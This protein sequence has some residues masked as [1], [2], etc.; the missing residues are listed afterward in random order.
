MEASY[1]AHKRTIHDVLQDENNE[2]P[3]A[4]KIDK[5]ELDCC[6]SLASSRNVVLPVSKD[7]R[8]QK[9]PCMRR[10]EKEISSNI[11]PAMRLPQRPRDNLCLFFAAL[12]VLDVEKQVAFTKGDTT[13]PE[14]AFLEWT[15][16]DEHIQNRDPL[17]KGYNFKDLHAYLQHL[18]K[19]KYITSYVWKNL[20]KWFKIP[21]QL[22][23]GDKLR[24]GR[25]LIIGGI[26][27]CADLRSQMRRKLKRRVDSLA[28][29]SKLERQKESVR[30]YQQFSFT[31]QWTGTNS[32]NHAIGVRQI[33]DQ[34]YIFDSG[35]R[36]AVKLND[37]DD[38]AWS[39]GQCCDWYEFGVDIAN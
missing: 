21:A 16:Q 15:K 30:F 32:S 36:A 35:R 4:L 11:V 24:N 3:E 23:F 26:A 25:A 18:L 8:V 39:L 34:P 1:T 38:I 5:Q 14:K 2:V 27:P 28:E 6:G 20:S 29:C 12:N 33:G 13:H 17:V 37:I 9:Q 31:T 7:L 22:L 19:E 10:E